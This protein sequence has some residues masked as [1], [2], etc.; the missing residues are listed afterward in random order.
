MTW[1][2][3]G[4]EDLSLLPSKVPDLRLRMLQ[5]PFALVRF[6]W[7]ALNMLNLY[8]CVIL[9]DQHETEASLAVHKHTHVRS[10]GCV[11]SVSCPTF[12]SS[13]SPTTL[14]PWSNVGVTDR[15]TAPTCV[16]GRASYGHRSPKNVPALV[17]S[18]EQSRRDSESS[19]CSGCGAVMHDL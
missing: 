17:P 1:L 3:H 11:S 13:S 15:C 7:V 2:W 5:P 12:S 16:P 14:K 8:V 19:R 9:P 4:P 10:A 18:K 6:V